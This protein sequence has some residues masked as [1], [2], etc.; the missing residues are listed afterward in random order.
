MLQFLLDTDHLTLLDH[1]HALVMQRVAAQPH[2]D[3]GLPVVTAEEYLRGRLTAVAQAKDGRAHIL[4]Y[5]YFVDTLLLVQ[6][7]K[8]ARFDQAAEDEFQQI[9]ARRLRIGS[10]DEKIAAIALAINAILVTRNKRDFGQIA[11][12]TLEDWSV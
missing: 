8:I 6:Q 11:G 4:R 9:R 7:F 5:G 3:V 10:Q 2:G 1:G 12:L